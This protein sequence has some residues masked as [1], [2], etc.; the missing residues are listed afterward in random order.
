M[1]PARTLASRTDV[2][3]IDDSITDLRVLLDFLSLRSLR[4]SVA[5]DGA[6]GYEQAVVL[7]PGVIL[8]DV[9]MPNIDGYAV[10]RLLKA[11][12]KT[13]QIP[14]IF[15]T[16]A[17][18]LDDRLTGFSLGAVDY[19]TKPFDPEEVLA[20]VGVHLRLAE[21]RDYEVRDTESSETDASRDAVLV[22]SAQRVLLHRIQTPPTLDELARM[23]GS[24]RRRLNEAFQLLCGQP[25]FG[26]FREERLRRAHDLLTNSDISVSVIADTLGY[27]T[28]ANFTKAFR[29][30]FGCSP[31]ELRANRVIPSQGS[32][33]RES[34]G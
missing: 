26:W 31:T 34:R 19:I 27:S 29:E 1:N 9:R 33:T 28:P 24:N 14:V 8:L 10:C 7:Q 11:N 2:I 5:S 4:I 21:R 22:R 15:L 32:T 23:V 17:T 13:A 6:R 3:L 12:K 25:V 30:R 16:S 20:R 18:D